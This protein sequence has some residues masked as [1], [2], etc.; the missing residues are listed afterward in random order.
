MYYLYLMS[1]FPPS[2]GHL[3]FGDADFNPE[4]EQ[5]KI[6]LFTM[7]LSAQVRATLDGDT[8]TTAV[9]WQK[10]QI[11]GQVAVTGQSACAGGEATDMTH[12][13][14]A[15]MAAKLHHMFCMQMAGGGWLWRHV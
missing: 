13:M 9:A 10:S 3:L 7:F 6:Q 2:S 15:H 14:C 8:Q 1:E 12:K 5:L 11:V 4:F